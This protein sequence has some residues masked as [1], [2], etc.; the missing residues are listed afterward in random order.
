[1]KWMKH[2]DANFTGNNWTGRLMSAEIKT[3][4]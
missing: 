4:F 2:D 1:L 3:W